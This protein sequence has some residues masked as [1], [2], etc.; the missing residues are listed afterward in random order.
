V[1]EIRT[2]VIARILSPAP[3]APVFPVVIPASAS[4]VELKA[5]AMRK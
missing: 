1:K 3:G 5:R 2:C 4:R